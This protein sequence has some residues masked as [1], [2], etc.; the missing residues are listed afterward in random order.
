[1]T[2]SSSSIIISVASDGTNQGQR[3]LASLNPQS[4]G[5]DERSLADFFDFTLAYSQGL[6][7][8]GPDNQAN[9][10]WSGLLNPDGLDENDWEAQR[11]RLIQF[12]TD[13]ENAPAV[14]L[15]GRAHLLLFA[16]YL[17]LLQMSQ[18]Q[19][20]QLTQ[21]H[22][23]FYYQDYLQLTNLA[24]VPDSVNV[25]ASLPRPRVRRLLAIQFQAREERQHQDT[26]HISLAPR[27]S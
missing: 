13:P 18:Q 26:Y 23:D 27:R 21:R 5:I 19:I 3:N 15:H 11:D 25:L 1:M 14:D 16:A 20:N 4:V 9:G 8:Y 10:D 22:L 2:D 7:Y 12:L 6:N 17:N 24:G